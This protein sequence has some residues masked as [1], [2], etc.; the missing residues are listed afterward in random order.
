MSQDDSL[1]CSP[2]C[3][4]RVSLAH[5]HRQA[6]RTDCIDEY[7]SPRSW[8]LE[9]YVETCD[10]PDRTAVRYQSLRSL[11]GIPFFLRKGM[12][13]VHYCPGVARRER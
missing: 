5:V 3:S 6:Y 2:G 1:V 8:S 9:A 12:H 11:A 7:R 10:A 13:G 4:R